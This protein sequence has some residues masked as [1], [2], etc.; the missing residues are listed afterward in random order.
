MYGGRSKCSLIGVCVCCMSMLVY[1]LSI[2]LIFTV[3][4]S[5]PKCFRLATTSPEDSKYVCLPRVPA[6]TPS[7][8][9]SIPCAAP[10]EHPSYG[11][12][13]DVSSYEFSV[14]LFADNTIVQQGLQ[15]LG[16]WRAHGTSSAIRRCG[17]T[18]SSPERQNHH[19]P[20]PK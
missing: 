8:G 3:F 2:I 20:S 6:W 12:S 13:C 14:R 4:S 7:I 15:N 11:T 1:T 9:L 16:V 19:H 17:S 18:S 5:S 10:K